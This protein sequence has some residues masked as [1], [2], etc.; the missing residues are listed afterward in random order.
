MAFLNCSTMGIC[1]TITGPCLAAAGQNPG[2]APPASFRDERAR[3][4]PRR[5]RPLNEPRER[6][7]HD[8]RLDRVRGLR[9][10][11][12]APPRQRALHATLRN[13]TRT[14]FKR[15][16]RIVA[17][18]TPLRGVVRRRAARRRERRREGHAGA[19]PAPQPRA[20]SRLAIVANAGEWIRTGLGPPQIAYSHDVDGVEQRRADGPR[21]G[22]GGGARGDGV[23]AAERPVL[24]IASRTAGYEPIR[25]PVY[26]KAR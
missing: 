1:M 11:G 12:S 9:H 7:R 24:T 19:P 25:N 21:C 18:Q 23:A 10:E 5:A 20:P 6:P 8:Q 14:F 2:T 16:A 26:V 15:R 4:S 22:A 3:P 17:P 13:V